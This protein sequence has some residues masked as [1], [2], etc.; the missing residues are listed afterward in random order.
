MG[1][2]ELDVST[3]LTTSTQIV[4]Q[5]ADEESFDVKRR[6]RDL[7]RR[8]HALRAAEITQHFFIPFTSVCLQQPGAFACEF[9]AYSEIGGTE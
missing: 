7:L 3:L 9:R 1:R 8:S 2:T 4:K 5:D 6:E